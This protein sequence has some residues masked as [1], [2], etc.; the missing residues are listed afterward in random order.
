MSKKYTVVEFFSC[1]FTLLI[2][3]GAHAEII[4]CTIMGSDTL[5]PNSTIQFNPSV[6]DVSKE[7]PSA[8]SQ[9]PEDLNATIELNKVVTGLPE[10]PNSVN[11]HLATSWDVVDEAIA[12]STSGPPSSFTLKGNVAHYSVEADCAVV[13]DPVTALSTSTIID[14]LKRVSPASSCVQ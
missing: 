3:A 1:L 8:T 2:C 11:M 13:A 7:S 5:K 4:R 10:Y 12:T 6:V 9:G 14:A